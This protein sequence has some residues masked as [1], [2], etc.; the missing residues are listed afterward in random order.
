VT[1]KPRW[2]FKGTTE[3]TVQH[4]VSTN[5]VAALIEAMGHGADCSTHRQAGR[6][7]GPS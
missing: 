3:A 1:V 6:S 4:L 5:F 7:R 2:N